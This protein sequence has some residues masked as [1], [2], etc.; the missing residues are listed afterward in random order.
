[1]RVSHAVTMAAY[2]TIATVLACLLGAAIAVFRHP[3]AVTVWLRR[4]ELRRS[5]FVKS[6][7]PTSIGPQTVW[8]GGQGRGLVLLHGAGVEAGTWYKV[9]PA[10]SHQYRLLMPDLAG[11]GESHPAAGALSLSTLVAGLEEVLDT[12]EWKPQEIILVGNSLGAWITLLYANKHPA[13][14]KR[15][16]LISGGPVKKLPGDV[17]L[18]P[19]TREEAR[20]AFDAVLDPSTR[21]PP[22]FV[23]DDVIRR[24]N[25]GPIARLNAAGEEDIAKHLLDGELSRF[26][27]PVDLLWGE[28]DRL[29]PLDYARELQHKL[30]GARLTVLEKCGHAPQL[31]R[32][33]TLLDAFTR[34]LAEDRG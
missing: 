30:P 5:G 27:C 20:R 31:E 18:T 10:L 22:G 32:P 29:V 8:Q 7:V 13:R 3:L 25:N 24:S 16:V 15:V 4:R 34:I 21:R 19:K 28:S 26:P 2:L 1:M 23:L 14:V 11:H 33:Q 6:Q 17:T 12:A 9:A